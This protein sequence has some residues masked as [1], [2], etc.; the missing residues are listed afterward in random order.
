M[1]DILART[2]TENFRLRAA[3]GEIGMCHKDES[4]VTILCE[5]CARLA[6]AGARGLFADMSLEDVLA[7]SGRVV[8]P[9]GGA[10]E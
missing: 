9:E 1:S 5:K 10:D 3:L 8:Q 4:Q 7:G 2:Q 6:E